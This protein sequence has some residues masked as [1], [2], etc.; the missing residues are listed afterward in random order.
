[1]M[2]YEIR[3][4]TMPGRSDEY[5]DV[6]GKLEDGPW[7]YE[8]T[9]PT[10]E[11]ALSYIENQ[12]REDAIYERAGELIKPAVEKLADQL[13]AE[14]KHFD[15]DKDEALKFVGERLSY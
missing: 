11:E 15:L 5:F 4:G 7:E 8:D 3:T 13:C 1:M 2:T 9:L 12:K 14:F 10:E 6:F